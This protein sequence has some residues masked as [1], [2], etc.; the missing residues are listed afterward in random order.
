MLL[1]TITVLLFTTISPFLLTSYV[2]NFPCIIFKYCNRLFPFL[3]TFSV[4][5]EKG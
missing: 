2:T 3:V 5:P 4:A 1:T